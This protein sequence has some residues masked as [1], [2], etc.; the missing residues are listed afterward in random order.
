MW[1]AFEHAGYAGLDNLI[2]IV[3]VNRLGQRGPTMHEWDTSSLAARARG[4][5]LGRAGD[6]RPRPRGD[7]R[8]LRAGARRPTARR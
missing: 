5:R 4:L 2:A 1:E 8:R 3:D 6:R 7:R